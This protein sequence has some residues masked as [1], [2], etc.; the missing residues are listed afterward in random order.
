MYSIHGVYGIEEW[1]WCLSAA[2][3]QV[4]SLGF[5][6]GTQERWVGSEGPPSKKDPAAPT[7]SMTSVLSGDQQLT[8]K[9]AESGFGQRCFHV[10]EQARVCVSNT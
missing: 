7:A 10:E 9:T 3:S 5:S 4:T 8:V 2:N 6:K 1:S